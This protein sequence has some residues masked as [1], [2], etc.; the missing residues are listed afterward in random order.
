VIEKELALIEA[1]LEGNR[2]VLPAAVIAAIL[3]KAK[4]RMSL[5]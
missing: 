1:L 2:P 4:T 5:K 3:A